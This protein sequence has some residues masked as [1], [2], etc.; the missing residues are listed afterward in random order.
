MQLP[1]VATITQAGEL[2]RALEAELDALQGGSTLQIDAS[3]VREF[4]TSL[5]AWLL[6]ARRRT[7]A[8]GAALQFDGAPPKL[9]ELA[10][11]YG[12]EDLLPLAS[13]SASA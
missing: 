1:A 5:L 3:A 8:Q 10:R 12:V 9:F 4:D 13:A 7:Q 2:L 11:L 6:Q